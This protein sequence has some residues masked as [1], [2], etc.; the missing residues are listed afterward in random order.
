MTSERRRLV[1][2]TSWTLASTLVALLAGAILSPILVLYLGV[3][4]Y[5]IW[6]SAIAVASLFG[7]VGDLGVSG[8]LTKL[9]AEREGN[10]EG[11]GSLAGT[12]V[13]FGLGTGGV[14]GGALAIVSR[15]IGAYGSYTAFGLLLI[16]QAVQMPFGVATASLLGLLQG[17]RH[18]RR[19]ALLTVVQSVAGVAL[20]ISLLLL[21]EGLVGV[22]V[23]SALTSILVFAMQL[24]LNRNDLAYHGVVAAKE[25]LQRL[26]P[27]G[28]QLT[29]T[30]ALST[31]L[32]QV[33]IVAL[34]IV[35][36][37]PAIV[38]V[39]ALAVFIT[40]AFWII[41]G[42]VSMTTYPV[43]SQYAAAK[44]WPRISRYLSTA[45]LASV[46]II[47]ALASAFILFGRPLLRLF[48]GPAS[49]GAYDLAL[50][51]L[52]GTGFLGCLRSVAPSIPA[53]GRPDIGLWISAAGAGSLV[54]LSLTLSSIFGA[55][56]TALAVCIS[57]SF[58]AALLVWAIENYVL[59]P[60]GTHFEFKKVLLT[61]GAGII[62]S[63]L[64]L[65]VALPENAGSS[66]V[67]ADVLIW[68]GI[69]AILGLVS[70]GRETWGDLLSRP[71]TVSPGR[72]G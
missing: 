58:V 50:V 37:N 26:V 42:S 66:A 51:L 16:I 14:A 9:V 33:D 60:T 15:F 41:P 31:M 19:L 1:L 10:P 57:F 22:M 29:A 55:A 20:T 72:E 47:G 70:G 53:A 13:V 35:S 68:A 28:I 46:A 49:L 65:L 25:D 5:G 38:G 44:E 69:A 56:G 11:L 63:T 71:R 34:S 61:S 24:I 30:N 62:G 27:F 54:V 3:D 43:T 67:A 23:A 59:R 52:V 32:Y 2:G 45:L 17:R 40:R 39:Y 7:I 4:G 21:G 6:A 18:F 8:A 12:A 48:F 36:G 64:S